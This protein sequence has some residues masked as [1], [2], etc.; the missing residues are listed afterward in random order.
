MPGPK[1]KKS[2]WHSRRIAKTREEKLTA[3]FRKHCDLIFGKEYASEKEQIADMM[4]E[5][6]NLQKLR[7][8]IFLIISIELIGVISQG[9]GQYSKQ[10]TL[11]FAVAFCMICTIG[12]M[13]Y[14][15]LR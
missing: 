14:S 3:E 15:C 10:K 8:Y 5:H 12:L 7:I 1:S 11:F 13:L 9:I 6:T 4:D 2:I